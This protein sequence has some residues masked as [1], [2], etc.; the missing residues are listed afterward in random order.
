MKA[1]SIW[2]VL[3]TTVLLGSSLLPAYGSTS[4]Q[5]KAAEEEKTSVESQ[6]QNANGH[7]SGL[8]SKKKE[9][10][11]YLSD[12]NKQLSSMGDTLQELQEEASQK[13]EELDRLKASLE[14]AREEEQRQYEGMKLRI[15]Y[16]Y[17]QSGE[18][19]VEV[20]LASEDFVDF[21]NKADAICEITRYD[22]EKLKD[23]KETKDL[24][25][26]KEKQLE[27]EKK[28]ID[29]L[30]QEQVQKQAQIEQVIL[31]TDQKIEEYKKQISQAEA[32]TSVYISN[33]EKQKKNIADL[34]AKAKSEEEAAKEAQRLAEQ[35][36]KRQEEAANAQRAAAAKAE[37][38]KAEVKEEAVAI[39]KAHQEAPE[40]AKQ[41][42]AK[43]TPKE[44]SSQVA[45]GQKRHLGRFKIT[46]YC[47][48]AKCCGSANKPTASGL[49]P[50]SGHTIAMAGVPFG[51]KLEIMGTVYTVEDRGTPY[52][53][54]D[55]FMDTH[56]EALQ[57]GLQYADVYQI[58]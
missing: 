10:E 1:K 19:Y 54:A 51:T 16:M 15:Q 50:R 25:A 49:M 12:L 43:E 44:S 58:D 27:E 48:C 32:A 38:P 41:A 9:T 11:A 21:L 28:Q 6:L 30:A 5:L 13:N 31:K 40:P 17:E 22:R 55:I 36:A 24:I 26:Q 7:L 46:A 34:K 18:S 42:P 47:P 52:G 37:E 2:S 23:Y 57:F 8:T 39:A 33:L 35:E 45:A 20:L 53:H 3:L 14:R 56:Q 4:D 29:A